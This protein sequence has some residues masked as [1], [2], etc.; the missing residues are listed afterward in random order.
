[1]N[2]EDKGVVEATRMFKLAKRKFNNNLKFQEEYL[3][4]ED[5]QR[6]MRFSEED[7]MKLWFENY[8]EFYPPE[9]AID[10][11][12]VYSATPGVKIRS[13]SGEVI[14]TAKVPKVDKH[15][16]LK[17]YFTLVGDRPLSDRYTGSSLVPNR[18]PIIEKQK[19][20][21]REKSEKSDHSN[22]YYQ[23]GRSNPKSRNQTIFKNKIIF[24]TEGAANI[25]TKNSFGIKFSDNKHFEKSV[26]NLPLSI[27]K[28]RVT[29][30]KVS[31]QDLMRKFDGRNH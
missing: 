1:L 18:T 16:T 14:H 17:D 3:S 8:R 31:Y 6:F 28:R 22:N 5:A 4:T 10:T 20:K 21:I 25:L 23:T 11:K 13:S 27:V 24:K 12:N 15:M 9:N 26:K 2:V 29:T 30:P 19:V 7:F